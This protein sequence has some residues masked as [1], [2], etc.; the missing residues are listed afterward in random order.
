[1]AA[2]VLAVLTVGPYWSWFLLVALLAAAGLWEYQRMV[3]QEGLPV[4]WQA[5]YITAG[6]LLPLGASVAGSDGLHAAL[7]FVF[8]AAF[9]TALAVSPEDANGLS[10][11]ARISMGWLYI[12]Y[13]LSYVLLIGRASTGNRW[14]FFALLVTVANDAGAYYCGR[15][16]GRHKLYERVSPKKTLEGSAGGLAAGMLVGSLFGL[17]FLETVSAGCLI[18]LSFVLALVGQIGDL[19][20]SLIKRMNGVKD[21]SNILPG[22]GGILDR[23]DSL[24]FV[25]PVLW[26]F[27]NWINCR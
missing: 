15:H 19:I 10:R 11:L 25:F 26:F 4:K 14:V 20:E 24:L 12:P 23:L 27:V 22:H 8:F 7:F 3:F 21:S 2:P 9:F 17:L 16:L 1:M 5:F 13:L 6:L 18:L